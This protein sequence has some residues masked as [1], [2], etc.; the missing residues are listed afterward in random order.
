[1]ALV[2]LFT[3][4]FNFLV[5]MVI[6]SPLSVT[7]KSGRG[8]HLLFTTSDGLFKKAFKIVYFTSMISSLQTSTCIKPLSSVKVTPSVPFLYD[9]TAA[10]AGLVRQQ[11]IIRNNNPQ[12]LFSIGGFYYCKY[13]G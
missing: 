4:I 5:V 3:S 10:V 2:V 12:I 11:L 7:L 8:S 1:M 9:L 6:V 13:N